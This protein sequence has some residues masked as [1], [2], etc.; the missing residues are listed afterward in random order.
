MKI[1][2]K[3][4]VKVDKV[5]LYVILD[6]NKVWKYICCVDSHVKIMYNKEERD[7]WNVIIKI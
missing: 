5:F 3:K 7:I 6:T 1:I 2:I 4:I